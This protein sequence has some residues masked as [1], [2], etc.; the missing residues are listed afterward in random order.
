MFFSFFTLPIKSLR[1][2]FAF[3]LIF[4]FY[5]FESSYPSFVSFISQP[6]CVI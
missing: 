3:A 5:D 2:L 4:S 6:A 1:L